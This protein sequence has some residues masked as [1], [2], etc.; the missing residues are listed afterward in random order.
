MTV[1]GSEHF[2]ALTLPSPEHPGHRAALALVKSHFFVL[3]PSN[4]KW[5]LGPAQDAQLFAAH[6]G[7]LRDEFGA[8]FTPNFERH[9]AHSLPAE[10]AAEIAPAVMASPSP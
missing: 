10:V 7:R 6:G 4:R 8:V 2:L 5:W 1:D 9:T 3:E